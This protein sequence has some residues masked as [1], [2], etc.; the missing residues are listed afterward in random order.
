MPKKHDTPEERVQK[1]VVIFLRN[2]RKSGVKIQFVHPANEL[3]RTSTMKMLYWHLGVEGGVPDLIIFLEGGRTI[4][5]ELKVGKNKLSENQ[6]GWQKSLTDMGF[7]HHVIT[8]KNGNLDEQIRAMHA[9][10]DILRQA[11]LKV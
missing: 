11:G 4:F 8:A 2:L 7:E 10:G 3:M 6:V 1:R 9:V 5:I